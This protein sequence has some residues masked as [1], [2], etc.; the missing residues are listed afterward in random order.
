MTLWRDRCRGPQ[1]FAASPKSTA[2][3]Y[4]RVEVLKPGFDFRGELKDLLGKGSHAPH[5]GGA[6]GKDPLHGLVKEEGN[7][8]GVDI[9]GKQH[10]LGK[11][12]AVIEPLVLGVGLNNQLES[13]GK[14]IHQQVGNLLLDVQILDGHGFQV[15]GH[16]HAH[17]TALRDCHRLCPIKLQDFRRL[18][19]DFFFEGVVD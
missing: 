13:L 10:S 4:T 1:A 11:H 18:L 16:V 6:G 8:L 2:A 19:G 12:P 17:G 9:G 14:V 7:Q 15:L 5:R 3:K